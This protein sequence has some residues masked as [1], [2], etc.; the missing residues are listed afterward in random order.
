MA[1]LRKVLL[2]GCFLLIL[3]GWSH[4]KGVVTLADYDYDSVQIHNRIVGFIIEHGMGY[5][6]E[7]TPGGAPVMFQGVVSGSIDLTMEGWISLLGDLYTKNVN[8]GKITNLGTNYEDAI[9]GWFVPTYLV[10]GDPARGITAAAPGL[11]S[12]SDLPR[13]WELFRD[14]EDPKKGRLFTGVAGWF[15][16]RT[17]EEKMA[18]Y[19]LE[20]TYNGF[21]AGSDTLLT[22]SMTSAYERGRP[23]LG[24]YFGPT[25]VLGKLDMTQLEE[26]PH[27]PVIW[28]KNRGCAYPDVDVYILVNR[29][30]EKRAPDVCA[31]LRRYETDFELNNQLLLHVKEQDASPE[32]AAIW[33]LTTREALWGSWV[34][35]EVQKRVK[36]AL[37]R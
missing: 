4:A 7:Y 36:Q 13:Y 8:A 11:K 27:D 31:F 29:K 17:S 18:A 21:V 9:Q 6:P 30:F 28:E 26:P 19:G 10:K 3:A 32:E 24:Y 5:T 12:V 33:F 34:T 23:W 1:C 37:E 25:W 15:A 35:P 14:P 2:T 22:A 20:D 16:T